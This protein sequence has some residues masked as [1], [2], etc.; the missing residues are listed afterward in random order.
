M[1]RKPR[2]LK[3]EMDRLT[4]ELREAG[5]TWTQV[6]AE[7][8]RRYRLNPRQAFR[9]AHRLT[10]AAVTLRWDALWPDDPL[11]VRKLGWWEAWP[12]PTGHEP[13]LA[14]LNRLA[15]IYQC[16]TTDLIDAEDH[17]PADPNTPHPPDSNV[18]PVGHAAQPDRAANLTFESVEDVLPSLPPRSPAATVSPGGL[19]R[20]EFSDLVHALTRWAERMKRRDALALLGAAATSAYASPTFE[21]LNSDEL[22]RLGSAVTDPARIDGATIT[23]I[24]AI[25]HH[26]MRQEYALGPHAALETVLAQRHL[27][28]HLLTAGV[29]EH[30]RVRLLSLL[31]NLSRCTGWML[32]N[33]G[34]FNAAE[35]YFAH[36]RT[37][38]HE[39]GDDAVAA[40]VLAN[41]SQL[42][43]WRG[44]PRQGLD[45]A[46]AATRWAHQ[47]GSQLLAA[48]AHD[49]EARAYA[50]IVS[51]SAAAE[52]RGDR[53]RCLRALDQAHNALTRIDTGDPATGLVYNYC[54]ANRISTNASCLI[55]M[56]YRPTQALDAARTALTRIDPAVTHTIAFTHLWIARAHLHLRDIEEACE[57]L[58]RA[59][60]THRNAYPRLTHT[61]TEI[62][63]KLSPWNRTRAVARLDEQ[64]HTIGLTNSR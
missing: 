53:T 10:Q 38:A 19:L 29:E 2:S 61:I 59:A 51:R 24:E 43:T 23:H 56:N 35:H 39:A 57:E 36:A 34:D 25:L 18:R 44:N 41:W 22:E 60:T 55:T 48:Y 37:S 62:R 45:H 9:E 49:V 14:A 27:V 63:E 15:R 50:G 30:N 58:A 32:F 20:R 42:A 47:A 4:A 16:R 26:S 3:Q 13:P 7:Y 54:D 31:A 28:H 52:S 1:P 6:A 5:W 21:R 12:G 64:L 33:L 17:T 40:L 11:S 46:L 8:R